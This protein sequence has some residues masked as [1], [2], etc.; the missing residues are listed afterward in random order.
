[1]CVYKVPGELRVR[2]FF[3]VYLR[4]QLSTTSQQVKTVRLFFRKN[5]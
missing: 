1:M 3:Y 2:G 5:S 4:V